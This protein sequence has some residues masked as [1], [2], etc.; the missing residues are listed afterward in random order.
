MEDCIG[1]VVVF[2][3]LEEVLAGKRGLI[4]E[5]RDLDGANRRVERGRRS[6]IGFASVLGGHYGQVSCRLTACVTGGLERGF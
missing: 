6:G 1:I 2:A 4:C 3:V 5:E